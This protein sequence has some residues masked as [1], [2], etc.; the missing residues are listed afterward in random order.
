MVIRTSSCWKKRRIRQKK[1]GVWSIQCGS[2]GMMQ[3]CSTYTRPRGSGATRF[4]HGLVSH[5]LSFHIY[6]TAPSYKRC[7][8][9][10]DSPADANDA[11]W[12]A[13]TYFLTGHY[14]RAERLLTEPLPKATTPLLPPRSNVLLNGNGHINGNGKGKERMEVGLENGISNGLH[15][16]LVE[17]NG[18]ERGRLV[19]ESL[20]CR[21]LVAQC[22][23]SCLTFAHI[24][25]TGPE[26]LDGDRRS[27][28]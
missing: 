24:S 19:D 14:L 3:L 2:G 7:V 23:V 25:W 12:L 5:Q 13:Q 8:V 26:G 4:C 6:C 16:V 22:L 21:Y 17:A 1:L 20:A 11:F 28:L 15:D 9:R 10:A 27:L 18:R